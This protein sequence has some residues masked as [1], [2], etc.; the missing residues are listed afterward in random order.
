M[1]L[2]T[3][4]RKG[5]DA[6]HKCCQACG[7]DTLLLFLPQDNN[8]G[9][10]PDAAGHDECIRRAN[11]ALGEL[12]QLPFPRFLCCLSS[13]MRVR[14]LIESFLR[15]RRRPF[16]E[17]AE[18]AAVA[19]ESQGIQQLT[20]R[21]LTLLLRLVGN[22]ELVELGKAG[23]TEAEVRAAYGHVLEGIRLLA[24]PNILDLS[25]IYAQANQALVSSLLQ[26]LV[27]LRPG[28]ASEMRAAGVAIAATLSSI[29]HQAAGGVKK[30]A[31]AEDLL[32]YLADSGATMASLAGCGEAGALLIQSLLGVAMPGGHAGSGLCLS[33][34][35]LFEHTAPVLE[36]QLIRLGGK[37]VAAR[38]RCLSAQRYCLLLLK[39]V[40]E[41]LSHKPDAFFTFVV[42]LAG[43][44]GGS[45]LA[46]CWQHYQIGNSIV[47]NLL[48]GDRA[49]Y[50]S[51]VIAGLPLLRQ[52]SEG[53]GQSKRSIAAAEREG[54][55]GGLGRDDGG[56]GTAEGGL[57]EK[58]QQVQSI[59]GGP[60]Q[61]G[62]VGAGYVEACLS[63]LDND[64]QRVIMALLE[65]TVPAV[66]AA[67]P[68]TL[69]TAWR[70][71]K[72][73]NDRGYSVDQEMAAAVKTT[74][75]AEERSQ[76]MQSYA[77]SREYGDDY[78]DQYD[79]VSRIEVGVGA[80]GLTDYESALVYNQA[81]KDQAE[82]D[83]YWSS[84]ANT[85]AGSSWT[86]KGWQQ[87]QGEEVRRR[88]R[89]GG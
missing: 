68:R 82:E 89:A 5:C 44:T 79:E 18:A 50:L 54:A 14:A 87:D 48:D 6:S 17:E 58:I 11:L 15:W 35:E 55:G 85:N 60:E 29:K 10:G 56:A 16:E 28:L 4:W 88:S 27:P 19:M 59:L 84:L 65:G 31:E 9:A 36:G 52:G 61:E 2:K 77:L 81:V 66:L 43:T 12:L 30:E 1:A 53:L 72:G 64:V 70:G 20:R 22:D 51:G 3:G 24:V 67:V 37:P 71:K 86:R 32:V 8:L 69:G 57:E 45:W 49:D 40:L 63:L 73:E 13:H 76:E 23:A 75:L 38:Q 62:G 42:D 80:G 34:A 47:R 39:R 7:D 33:L 41:G 21:V 83:A 78:D 26:R 25:A 46:E 74:A